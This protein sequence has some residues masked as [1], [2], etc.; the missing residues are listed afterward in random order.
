MSL[1]PPYAVMLKPANCSFDHAQ[2]S[3]FFTGKT[4][5]FYL[6]TLFYRLIFNKL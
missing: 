2:Q 4:F 1:E 6:I 3:H 5:H